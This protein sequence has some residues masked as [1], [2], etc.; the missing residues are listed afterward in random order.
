MQSLVRLRELYW[1][2][3][4]K[5]KKELHIH[6]GFGKLLIKLRELLQLF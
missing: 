6:V 5:R 1:N 2:Y 3:G 4:E